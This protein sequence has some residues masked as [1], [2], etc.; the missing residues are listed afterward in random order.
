M[1]VSD[2]TL[3]I[4][5]TKA[6]TVFPVFLKLDIK[7]LL[8]IGGGKTAYTIIKSILENQDDA[9]ITILSNKISDYIVNLSKAHPTKVLFIT[10]SYKDEYIT[11]DYGI[12]IATEEELHNGDAIY[13]AAKAQGALVNINNISNRSDFYWGYNIEN[14]ELNIAINSQG[15]TTED[16]EAIEQNYGLALTGIGNFKDTDGNN[17][18]QKSAVHWRTIATWCLVIFASMLIGHFVFSY[19]PLETIGTNIWDGIK[20]LDSNFPLIMAA[21]FVAQMVDGALGMGYGLASATVLNSVG[22]NPAA[23]SASIHTAEMFASGASGYSHYKFGNVNKKL[24]KLIVIP[25]VIG[26]IVGA[27]LLVKL[28]EE[29]ADYIRPALA[30]YTLILGIKFIINAFVQRRPTKKF[31]LYGP[32]AGLGGFFDSFGGG[33][34]GPIVTSTLINVGRTPRFVIG[35]VSLTEFFV[36]L[37]SAFA[38]FLM[39]GVTHWQVIVALILGGLIAAPIAAKLV[40]KM[41]RKTAFLLLGALVIIWSLKIIWGAIPH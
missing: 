30:C 32:L 16:I 4:D 22:V 36:T 9:Q 1:T 28:G 29:Y 40:G 12:V 34:W 11:S 31:K 14:S 5:N 24:F 35:T 17:R 10:D 15:K 7:K 19:I 27:I 25:G 41:P 33:G 21:G 18:E 2:H 37:S 13:G 20:Q 3:N 8:I 26:A 39:M 23:I 6:I 38:F